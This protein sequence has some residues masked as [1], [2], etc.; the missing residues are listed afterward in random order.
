MKIY[1]K[2]ITPSYDLTK[3]FGIPLVSVKKSNETK[4][5]KM[6]FGI[7]KIKETS[8]SKKC[9]FLGVCFYK[10]KKN[11]NIYA[12]L[13]KMQNDIIVCTASKVQR[14]LTVAF[15]HQKTFG[16]MKNKHQDQSMV[17][18]GAGPTVNYFEPIKDAVYVGLNRACLYNK[19]HFNYLFAID[20][21]GLD[22]GNVQYYEQFMNYDAL[23]FVGD[24][25]FGINFQI[26]ESVTNKYSNVRRYKTT[27]G[28]LPNRFALDIETQALGNYASVA[29]QAIQFILYTNPKRVYLVG[30]DC[31]I[32]SGQ[33]FI[34]ESYDNSK[35]NENA[36]IVDN[37]NIE[38]WRSLKN[39]RNPT[40]LTEIISVSG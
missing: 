36:V 33:H 38:A 13:Q 11:D 31:T 39:P 7:L 12:Y 14:A 34:G 40:G 18:F 17:L 25:N 26:P 21:A 20:K 24:Q 35:R 28:Y 9:Y 3:V 37:I 32:S 29:L 10:K 30:I 4:K 16:D 6:L 8:S 15:L 1:Q 5:K 27:M 23:K 2:I 22:T 19:I